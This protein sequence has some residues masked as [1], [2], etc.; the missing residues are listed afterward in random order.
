MR[1]LTR[2]AKEITAVLP[3]S[4]SEVEDPS[5]AQN[6][7]HYGSHSSLYSFNT[8]SGKTYQ[9]AATKGLISDNVLQ[10][11]ALEAPQVWEWLEAN[12]PGQQVR[13]IVI[14]FED[15]EGSQEATGEA[16]GDEFAIF[17]EVIKATVNILQQNANIP[18]V[19]F[20]ADSRHGTRGS[21][22]RMYERFARKLSGQNG[23]AK[24]RLG[25][26][27]NY[28]A[29]N[30][31]Y[32]GQVSQEAP[33]QTQTA[34]RQAVLR[35]EEIEQAERGIDTG[36]IEQHEH[37]AGRQTVPFYT[38]SGREYKVFFIPDYEMT[39][40]S[41]EIPDELEY[42]V[43]DLATS[44]GTIPFV[45]IQF[46]DDRGSMSTTG[47]GR[48]E[49]HDILNKVAAIVN[50]W[51]QAN[52]Q[53]AVA[54]FS[55]TDRGRVAIYKRLTRMIN[56][57][58]NYVGGDRTSGKFYAVNPHYDQS[59]AEDFQSGPDL[60]DIKYDFDHLIKSNLPKLRQAE[61]EFFK[62]TYSEELE[63]FT[64]KLSQEG[65]LE[66]QAQQKAPLLAYESA[67]SKVLEWGKETWSTWIYEHIPEEL[68]EAGGYYEDYVSDYTSPY[69]DYFHA[70]PR[71]ASRRIARMIRKAVLRGAEEKDM[72]FD[73][74]PVGQGTHN[75]IFKTSS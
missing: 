44:G 1:R 7:Q 65:Q 21:R 75:F 34:S 33:A 5:F 14:A 22:S 41:Y 16:K 12:L 36:Y 9:V 6:L 23:Y 2:I 60:D 28:I 54:Y 42:S 26:M 48:G 69:E 68:E 38:E 55:G 30:P 18:L 58:D 57:T 73:F 51:L 25:A 35:P 19:R 3:R 24:V 29:I 62:Q 40:S 66:H 20:A 13:N 53:I 59:I 27:D 67:R 37:G 10:E 63:Y 43:G 15:E 45:E 70:L 32:Q 74:K 61:D 11:I 50:R 52:P 56:P 46:A 31:Y 39:P 72:G 49:V 4:L 64:Q 71:E 8:P 47:G 17:G